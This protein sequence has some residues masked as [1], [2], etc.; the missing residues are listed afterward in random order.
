[1]LL[2]KI[3]RTIITYFLVF[4][5]LV[6]SI[7]AMIVTGCRATKDRYAAARAAYPPI[8]A[9]CSFLLFTS[10]VRMTVKGM[11]HIPDDK[12]V[13]F[14]SNHRSYFDIV[15][16]LG[17]VPIACGY[18]AKDT[19]AHFPLLSNWMRLL[20]CQFL[21]RDDMKKDLEVVIASIQ[22]LKDGYSMWVCPE[23]TRGTSDDITQPSEFR[24]GAMKLAQKS[25]CLVIPVAI[26]GTR[27]VFE[28]RFPLISGGDVTMVFGEGFYI[29][30]LEKEVQKESGA[31]ARRVIIDMLK[32]ELIGA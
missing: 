24:Q 4:A 30:D 9:I 28:E 27:E 20:L 13:L 23:G 14:V 7:P 11:E 21:A 18:M 15:A 8:R 17:R 29:S 32:Q 16:A 2:V 5:F 19:L 25:G 31:Y 12:P 10:G 1:M 22:Q 26:T 6:L 3:F